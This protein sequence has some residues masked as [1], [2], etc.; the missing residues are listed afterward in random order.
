MQRLRQQ[1][2]AVRGEADRE[3]ER[4]ECRRSDD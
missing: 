2:E 4:H 1:P 3:L